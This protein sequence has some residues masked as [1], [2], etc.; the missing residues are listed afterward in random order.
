VKK[1]SAREELLSPFRT[2][3]ILGEMAFRSVLDCCA[4]GEEADTWIQTQAAAT[5][6]SRSISG[7]F[8]GLDDGEIDCANE[9]EELV[10]VSLSLNASR[11]R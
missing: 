4:C 9:C 8:W 10:G 3:C 1:H 7:L 2:I 5:S 11:L 6:S